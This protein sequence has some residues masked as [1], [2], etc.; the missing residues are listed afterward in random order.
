MNKYTHIQKL[1]IL[2]LEGV[3]A[4]YCKFLTKD[5]Y[6]WGFYTPIFLPLLFTL[7]SLNLFRQVAREVNMISQLASFFI[8]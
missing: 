1:T 5:F 8:S 4:S 7:K 3:G 6:F 2:G